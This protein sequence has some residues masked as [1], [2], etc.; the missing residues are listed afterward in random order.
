MYIV[1]WWV[2][3]WKQS[4]CEWR[5]A[6]IR[7]ESSSRER[8]RCIWGSKWTYDP[9]WSVNY[10]TTDERR[11]VGRQHVVCG[12]AQLACLLGKYWLMFAIM[13]TDEY[14]RALTGGGVLCCGWLVG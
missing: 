2:S 9:R 13:M 3:A 14:E 5:G 11:A 4:S 6:H 12:V 1:I 10:D 7:F 8:A